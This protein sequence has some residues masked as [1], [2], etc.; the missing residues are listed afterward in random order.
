MDRLDA[1]AR[2]DRSAARVPMTG[3]GAPR[4]DAARTEAG[5]PAARGLLHGVA[6]VREYGPAL[7]TWAL[8][9]LFGT[10]LAAQNASAPRVVE[11]AVSEPHV[12]PTRDPARPAIVLI[13]DASVKDHGPGEGWGDYLAPFVDQTRIQ[14]LNWATEG[15]TPRS[16]IERGRWQKALAPDS[17]TSPRQHRRARLCLFR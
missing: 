6:V 10:T 4:R 8:L 2:L 5:A 13:G 9:L 3:L 15:E 7:R 11:Q 14:I 1:R 12:D 16:F 17:K